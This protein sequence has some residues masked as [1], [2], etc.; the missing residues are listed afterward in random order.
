MREGSFKTRWA[1]S[2]SSP[3][4]SANFQRDCGEGEGKARRP[5]CAGLE[6]SEGGRARR[7]CI[8]QWV[9]SWGA[10]QG[11]SKG[12]APRQGQQQ[13]RQLPAPAMTPGCS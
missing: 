7:L 11:R 12:M 1:E 10:M 8:H 9:G 5:Q 6:N 2:W 13:G 4:N 3:S